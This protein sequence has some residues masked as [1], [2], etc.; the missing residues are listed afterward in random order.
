MLS[1]LSNPNSSIRDPHQ[2]VLEK[3]LESP[4][5]FK[6]IKTSQSSRKSG[7]NILWKD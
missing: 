2:V 7:L 6:E 3:T 1:Q 4:L 5:D